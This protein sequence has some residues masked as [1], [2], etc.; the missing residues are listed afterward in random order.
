M[1]TNMASASLKSAAAELL[2]MPDSWFIPGM[3]DCCGAQPAS[4]SA[5]ATAVEA[6]AVVRILFIVGPYSFQF[7][8]CDLVRWHVEATPEASPELPGQIT[9][10]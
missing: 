7:E 1:V 3:V 2:I 5:A 9:F 4:T 6:I 8:R 10:D